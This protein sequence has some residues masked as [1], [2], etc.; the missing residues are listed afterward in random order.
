M[1]NETPDHFLRRWSRRKQSARQGQPVSDGEEARTLA[2]T[3]GQAEPAAPEAHGRPQ[4]DAGD[5]REQSASSKNAGPVAEDFKDIDF[6][7]LDF[8][9]DYTRFMQRGVPEDVRNKALKKLWNS[10]PV[11]ANQ[12]GLDDYIDD[13]TDAAVAVAAGTL[14]TAY[15]F[16]QGFLSDEEAAEWDRL[17]KP[18]PQPEAE[19]EPGSD[20]EAVVAAGEQD[21]TG[22]PSKV[23]ETD[24]VAG[25]EE[26]QDPS[27]AIPAAA[28]GSPDRAQPIGLADTGQL[29]ARDADAPE[30][31]GDE[32]LDASHA[33]APERATTGKA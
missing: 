33:S 24:R 5:R 31:L 28:D 3:T 26:P 29:E 17:G 21:T 2:E 8:G 23:A 22:E 19:R 9:S 13:Y 20:G 12:D 1:T 25:G 14:K 6:D 30:A 32:G 4:C 10:N 18:E 27:Q 7:A 16:G 15:K 11:L